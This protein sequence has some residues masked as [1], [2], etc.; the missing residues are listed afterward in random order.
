[1]EGI[2]EKFIFWESS[3]NILKFKHVLNTWEDD[4]IKYY[5]DKPSRPS[6]GLIDKKIYDRYVCI[7]DKILKQKEHWKMWLKLSNVYEKIGEISGK[8]NEYIVLNEIIK[9]NLTLQQSDCYSVLK[10]SNDNTTDALD[11][12]KEKMKKE[13]IEYTRINLQHDVEKINS[14]VSRSNMIICDCVVKEEEDEVGIEQKIFRDVFR[15]AL[16]GV[17]NQEKEGNLII[18]INNILT[19]PTSQLVYI[20]SKFYEKI[21]IVKPR[22]SNNIESERYLVCAKYVDTETNIHREIKEKMI[23]LDKNWTEKYCRTLGVKVAKEFEDELKRYNEKTMESQISSMEMTL[24]WIC[25]NNT[26]IVEDI[27]K[28]QVRKAVEYCYI[29]GLKGGQKNE[30]KH[31]KKIKIQLHEIKNVMV[32]DKCLCVLVG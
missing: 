25:K 19:R 12:I 14:I 29:Y 2:S 22:C 16:I 10:I 20:L 4:D 32:C 8:T 1:M 26:T 13:S 6:K 17:L 5:S 9:G 30:C 18:K 11:L 7:R 23:E 28:Y 27:E 24:K 31:T 15:E 21:I 3:E